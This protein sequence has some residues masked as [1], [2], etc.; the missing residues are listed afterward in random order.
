MGG[1][2]AVHSL[3]VTILKEIYRWNITPVA[4]DL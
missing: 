1:I 3:E 2:E 4:T